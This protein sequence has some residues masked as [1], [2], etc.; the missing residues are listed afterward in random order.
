MAEPLQQ[1]KRRKSKMKDK[2]K[3]KRKRRKSKR[4]DKR[5][6]KRERRKPVSLAAATRTTKAAA[7]APAPAAAAATARG[8]M[9]RRGKQLTTLASWQAKR[10]PP[11]P[12]RFPRSSPNRSKPPSPRSK[13]AAARRRQWRRLS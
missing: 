1:M 10:A 12:R 4:K 5:K 6:G 2:R 13:T 7:A 8:E 9:A 3:G 11:S